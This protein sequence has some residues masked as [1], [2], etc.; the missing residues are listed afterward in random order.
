VL[1][2]RVG[3]A[4]GT[5]EK[6]TYRSMGDHTE[7]ISIDFDP[8]VVSYSELLGYFWN[9]HRCD[10]SNRSRQYMNAVFYQNDKQRKVAENSRAQQAQKLGISIG[11][12]KTEII[13]VKQFT[14][15]ENYHQKYYLTRQS[16]V[17]NFLSKTYPDSKSLAD[18]TVATRLNA[19]LG[20]G[21]KLDWKTFLKELPKYG[22]PQPLKDRLEKEAL[23]K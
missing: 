5:K 2:T 16:D 11:D 3:Y 13:P 6:P 10:Y 22:L 14:Y 19:Y 1:R 21:M 18:S 4:G 7:A 9:A 15:A 8:T 17:R 23:R 12:V 20:S